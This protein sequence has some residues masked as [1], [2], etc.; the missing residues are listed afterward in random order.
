M[1]KVL[2]LNGSPRSNGCT[3]FA[4]QEMVKTFEKEGIETEL[5]QIGNTSTRGLL[6]VIFAKRMVNV[7]LTMIW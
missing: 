2:L 7:F 5:I 4:L 3:A 6:L 1:A